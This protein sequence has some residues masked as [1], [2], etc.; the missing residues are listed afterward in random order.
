MVT[1]PDLASMATTDFRSFLQQ[2]LWSN[3]AAAARF[4]DLEPLGKITKTSP[5]N[6]RRNRFDGPHATLIGDARETVEPFTGEGVRY[7]L[8][9]GIATAR[10][11]VNERTGAVRGGAGTS[12]RFRVNRVFSPALRNPAL[13]GWLILLGAR[14]PWLAR[15]V[16]GTVLAGRAGE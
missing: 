8:E 3:A 13:G 1:T 15:W 2:T 5:I 11:L 4:R 6:P 14:L 10:R 7:A 12:S 16:A 9:D